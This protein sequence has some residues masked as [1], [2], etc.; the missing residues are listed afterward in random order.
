MLAAVTGVYAQSTP[1]PAA[2]TPEASA[3]ALV[4][5]YCVFCHND[6]LKTAGVSLQG[7]HTTDIGAGAATWERVFRKVRSGEMPPLGMPKPDAAASA[8][9]VSWLESRLDEAAVG[10]PNPGSLAVHRLNRAEYSNAIRDLLALDMDHSATLPAD[11]SGYGFDNIGD[12]ADG[13][14][15]VDGKVHEHGA[16]GQQAG[17]GDGEGQPLD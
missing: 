15:A 5:K 7:I 1:A 3:Q 16:Q 12:V 14:A 4:N 13:F 11:D 2:A 6:K 10:N 17:G 8:Q 9:F